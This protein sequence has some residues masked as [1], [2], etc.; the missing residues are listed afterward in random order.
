MQTIATWGSFAIL[1]RNSSGLIPCC[2]GDRNRQLSPPH[3]SGVRLTPAREHAARGKNWQFGRLNLTALGFRPRAADALDHIPPPVGSAL[4]DKGSNCRPFNFIWFVGLRE[5]GYRDIG[6]CEWFGGHRDLEKQR[7][8]GAS[9]LGERGMCG[10]PIVDV[11]ADKSARSRTAAR[12]RACRG[13]SR[14]WRYVRWTR[15]TRSQPV[16]PCRRTRKLF[17]RRTSDAPRGQS[18]VICPAK[19]LPRP[20]APSRRTREGET[21][22]RTPPRP[23]QG[24]WVM[25]PCRDRQAMLDRYR[26]GTSQDARNSSMV[27]RRAAVMPLSCAR[28]RI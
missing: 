24:I 12:H 10:I 4:L 11:N 8:A 28:G 7:V 16:F 6:E 27:R 20:R 18:G 26:E 19:P 14:K 23:P 5:P 25:R 21:C 9:G 3:D 2:A 22:G 1:S 15:A 17:S 13:R